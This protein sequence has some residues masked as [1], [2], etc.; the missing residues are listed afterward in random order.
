MVTNSHLLLLCLRQ[1]ILMAEG[2]T[3]ERGDGSGERTNKP[4]F[5]T[6]N[7]KVPQTLL[8]Q[9]ELEITV[10]TPDFPGVEGPWEPQEWAKHLPTVPTCHGHSSAVGNSLT[11]VP[12]AI[13]GLLYSLPARVLSLS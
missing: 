5:G 2:E 8:R 7:W 13:R 1:I 3:V 9:M 12:K 11:V 6:K 10:I 4:N